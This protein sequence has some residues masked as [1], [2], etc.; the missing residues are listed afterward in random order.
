M[1][2]V[3]NI[4]LFDLIIGPL[5]LIVALYIMF[6]GAVLC[7][8]VEL[9]QAYG[10][11]FI[12]AGAGL[13][14][15]ALISGGIIVPAFAFGIKRHNR[16]IILCCFVL[17]TIVMSCL[18]HLGSTMGS[19]LVPEF[20]KD[21][22]NACLTRLPTADYADCRKFLTSDRTSGFRLVWA[23]IFTE[24]DDEMQYQVLKTI[25]DSTGCCGFY[26]PMQ[27]DPITKGFPNDRPTD[28]IMSSLT[29]Q[30][31]SCGP[32]DGYYPV[33]DNCEHVYDTDTLPHIIGGC[34]FDLAIGSQCIDTVPTD[35]DLGCISG[36]EDYIASLIEMHVYMIFAI[37]PLF[38][39]IGMVFTCCMYW[40]RKVDQDVFPD[41]LSEAK[42]EFSYKNVK[43]Q[44]EVVPVPKLLK[45]EGFYAQDRYEIEEQKNA[46]AQ[47]EATGDN[48]A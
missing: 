8:T 37:C 2:G 10:V 18:L 25:Q 9:H 30:R 27:C 29:E 6:V 22:Q 34:R 39:F 38:N 43:D 21:L 45:K 28:G 19:Y 12:E 17:D 40:K 5:K 48:P 32:E 35:I 31:M 3:E 7:D 33:Q 16:F 14:M 26:P 44:F 15:L 4:K 36:V 24:M 20:D 47:A 23:G 11:Y 1:C 13:I 42:F 46:D 41:F